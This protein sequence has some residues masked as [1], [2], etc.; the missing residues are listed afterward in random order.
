MSNEHWNKEWN[1]LSTYQKIGEIIGPSRKMAEDKTKLEKVRDSIVP[2]GLG[3]VS[4]PAGFFAGSKGLGN[5]I[6][7]G[8][9]GMLMSLVLN[10][11]IEDKT[12][13]FEKEA[14]E[15]EKVEV[16]HVAGENIHYSE[17]PN[18]LFTNSVAYN[19]LKNEGEYGDSTTYL[20]INANDG[21]DKINGKYKFEGFKKPSEIDT[22]MLNKPYNLELGNEDIDGPKGRKTYNGLLKRVFAEE[23]K[24]I[25]SNN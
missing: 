19:S 22:S 11:Y 20:K 24:N 13:R 4:L 3:A 5:R 18:Y 23:R 6:G 1:E 2:V 8:V 12:Q 21:P 16:R 7:F 17:I 9:F 10:G 14:Y 25:A 15:S